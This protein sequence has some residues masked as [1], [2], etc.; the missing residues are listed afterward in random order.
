MAPRPLLEIRDLEV[1][2][3]VYGGTLKVLDG[4]N[5]HVNSGEK[6]GLVGETG[7]GKT[8]TMKAI[9]R[10]L[11][12]PPAVIAGGE[13]SF[14]GEDI[15]RMGG[16]ALREVRGRGIS[17]IFQDPTAALNPVFT[18]GQQLG[19][20]IRYAAPENRGL[21]KR[22]IQEKAVIPL[23]EVA[24]ADPERLLDSYPIQLSGG[25]RQRVCIG[26]ALATD[27]EL[28]IADEPGTSLDV[29]IQ[30]QV[31]RLLHRLVE[32]K[33]TSVILITHTLGV[34]RETTDRVYVMYAGNMVE[35][36]PTR[37]L[38]SNPLHPYTQGLMDAVPRLTGGGVAHGIPGRIPEYL[39]P[40]S[41]CRFHTRCPHVMDICRTEKPPYFS[42]DG[43]Q[44]V[45]CF[46]YDKT[47]ESRKSATVPA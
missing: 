16:N 37:R 12:D 28:L 43:G 1:H 30:D 27:P 10:I 31:L 8:T 38:F 36:A 32:E 45:A 42:V 25:M 22:Q 44:E 9:L 6:V 26:M 13:I 23:R 19:P 41:G 20:V 11:P 14:K 47:H 34:V 4:V 21:S 15:L 35:V 18:I 33:Q 40:P 7:C 2:Y 39:S 24:L 46:L 5:F 17:M 3:K 29:T